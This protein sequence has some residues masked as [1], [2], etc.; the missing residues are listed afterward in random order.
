MFM[1][2][3]SVVLS[4]IC[5]LFRA[6]STAGLFRH[7]TTSRRST[8]TIATVPQCYGASTNRP[9]AVVPLPERLKGELEV[10]SE[11]AQFVL[12][13]VTRVSALVFLWMVMTVVYD[14]GL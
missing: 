13:I 12:E 7:P 11:K 5:L 8:T 14:F 10:A 2:K 3:Y 4:I 9:R 6:T 1:Y